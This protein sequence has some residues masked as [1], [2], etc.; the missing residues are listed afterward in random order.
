MNIFL[1]QYQLFNDINDHTN[2]ECIHYIV[3]NCIMVYDKINIH[4]L[5]N[6]IE[7]PYMDLE[8]KYNGL[9][10]PYY[11]G[12]KIIGIKVN[13]ENVYNY[14]SCMSLLNSYDIITGEKIQ[15]I[16][17]IVIG[18]CDSLLFNPNNSKYSKIMKTI[19]ELN[20]I[21]DYLILFVF[22]HNLEEF[23]YK[24]GN[25]IENKIIISH[26]SDGEIKYVMPMKYHFAQNCL[27]THDKLC[28][29]PIGIENEQWFDHNIFYEINQKRTIKTKDIYFYFNL[30]TH[31]SRIECYEKLKDKLEWNVKRNKKEYFIELSNHK[32]A[33]CPRGNGLDTHRIWECLYLNVIP[34]VIKNDYLHIEHLPIIVLND[35][36]E[37]DNIYNYTFKN[38]QIDKLR[39]TYYV[40]K[41]KN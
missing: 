22:T 21:N 5:Y 13:E 37:I 28:P 23:Y 38:Q 31:P 8:F 39:Y 6:I 16:A 33:I 1:R 4:E 25:Q 17:D 32:Y 26:N 35:W 11:N 10:I 24:F 12:V 19:D 7:I 3:T 29:I 40:N 36:N 30:N 2:N 14:I 20:D 27:I 18:N 34:I 9:R 41:I 15:S